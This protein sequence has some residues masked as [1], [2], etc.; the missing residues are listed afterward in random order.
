MQITIQFPEYV[1]CAITIKR[2]MQR[3]YS[4]NHYEEKLA[5]ACGEIIRWYEHSRTCFPEIE[6]L[7][8]FRIIHHKD[9]PEATRNYR[10]ICARI[11]EMKCAH[12]LKREG[13]N[14]LRSLLTALA[15]KAISL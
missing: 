2:D 3:R 15:D 13:S 11:I 5:I 4:F 9:S 14:Q 1:C 7:D 8:L 12:L 6:V 10:I